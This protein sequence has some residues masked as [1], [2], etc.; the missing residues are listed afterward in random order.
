VEASELAKAWIDLKK[1]SIQKMKKD[2]E[3]KK[4]RAASQFS[5]ES[6]DSEDVNNSETDIG[7]ERRLLMAINHLNKPENTKS[8]G[9]IQTS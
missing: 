3:K 7:K 4:K 5:D 1:W 9:Y 8:M 6:Q 2:L